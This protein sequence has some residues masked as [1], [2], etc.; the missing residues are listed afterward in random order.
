VH[1]YALDDVW[2]T[3]GWYQLAGGE[4]GAIA[5]TRNNHVYWYAHSWDGK[6]RWNDDNSPHVTQVG[7]DDFS[8]IEG[9]IFIGVPSVKQKF[10]DATIT[11][12]NWGDAVIDVLGCP[13]Q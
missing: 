5:S 6:R 10:R 1:Y 2:I 3:D 11:N 4:V 12:K 7:E 8:Q 13:A 9:D